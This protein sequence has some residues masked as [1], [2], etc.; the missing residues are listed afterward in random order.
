MTA[1][2][3]RFDSKWPGIYVSDS[4]RLFLLI[5]GIVY[6]TGLPYNISGMDGDLNNGLPGEKP[7]ND[8][9]DDS[10]FE[11][12]V[13]SQI[14]YIES[15]CLRAVT[16]MFNRRA[17]ISDPISV[18][19]EALELFNLVLDKLQSNHY[20]ILRQFKRKAKLTTYLNTIISNLAVDR[21]RKKLGRDRSRD[22][23]ASFG[24]LG[25]RVFELSVTQGLPLAQIVNV[26]I[27]EDGLPGS[28]QELTR[29]VEIIL[30][31]I[32]AGP[33]RAA[34]G[35]AWGIRQ[36]TG[37]SESEGPILVDERPGPEETYL[38]ENSEKK[39][40]LI[41]SDLI[42]GMSAEERMIIRM[43]YPV[44]DSDR[45]FTVTEI[46]RTVG[47]TPKAVY[48]RLNRILGRCLVT[49]RENGIQADDLFKN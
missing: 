47:I 46:A 35:E 17:Q 1:L 49:L 39:I 4:N 42:A 20:Q 25:E 30:D 13:S 11:R 16:M 15:Q 29:N 40:Q 33:S 14:M 48:S 21:V 8:F 2:W 36:A 18:E 12:I 44:H 38:S 31:R 10:R 45:T 24:K 26:L 28:R 3:H 5:P 23:A 19:N 7:E 43:R 37:Q 34:D 22:R 9:G 6:D 32:R 41:I 27:D